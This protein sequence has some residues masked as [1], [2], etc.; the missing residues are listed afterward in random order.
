MKLLLLSVAIF[1]NLMVAAVNAQ[2]PVVRKGGEFC[3]GYLLREVA[4]EQVGA[5]RI[6]KLKAFNTA[7]E[8]LPPELKEWLRTS[9]HTDMLAA[10]RLRH[11]KNNAL[12]IRGTV[13]GATGIAANFTNWY[14]QPGAR[15]V[16]FRSL[17]ENP[18]LI[19]WDK[20]GLLNYY[21]VTYTDDFAVDRDWGNVTFDLRRYRVGSN[22]KAQ[23]VSEER[24]VKCE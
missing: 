5:S 9:I 23:L 2:K 4:R 19:F 15:P 17:T 1:C 22:G 13:A 20:G 24:N 11:K 7:D 6:V 16:M 8:T 12:I 18:Q 21:F 10:F 3:E 14:V